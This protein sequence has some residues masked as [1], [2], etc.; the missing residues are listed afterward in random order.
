MY[1]YIL[2]MS[3]HAFTPFITIYLVP[4]PVFLVFPRMKS[5]RHRGPPLL[6]CL[7]N[8]VYFLMYHNFETMILTSWLL[9]RYKEDPPVQ[10]MGRC[11]V[12]ADCWS[13]MLTYTAGMTLGGDVVV[14][15]VVSGDP[16]W[17]AVSI[18]SGK[19]IK[20]YRKSLS[21]IGKSTINGPFSTGEITRG[22]QSLWSWLTSPLRS[23][24]ACKADWMMYVTPHCPP[25]CLQAHS[26]DPWGGMVDGYHN[27]WAQSLEGPRDFRKVL[28]IFSTIYCSLDEWQI[29]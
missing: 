3:T 9:I 19:H 1:R 18:P 13:A 2:N 6:L 10:K 28:S 20:S 24:F 7:V 15:W 21:F 8:E 4:F 23:C 27:S 22:V 26:W 17:S 25:S 11:E 5:Q 12:H 14:G 29:A 16:Q